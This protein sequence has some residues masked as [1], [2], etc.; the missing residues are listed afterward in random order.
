M[1]EETQKLTALGKRSEAR[2]FRGKR[3]GSQKLKKVFWQIWDAPKEL[4]ICLAVSL[5]LSIND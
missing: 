2:G 1:Q 3:L 5:S 4:V